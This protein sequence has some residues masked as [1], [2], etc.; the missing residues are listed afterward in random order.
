MFDS[1]SPETDRVTPPAAS[2]VLIVAF[3]FGDDEDDLGPI[4]MVCPYPGCLALD[5]I[6]Q[7]AAMVRW[8]GVEY[9]EEIGGIAIYEGRGAEDEDQGFICGACERP[10][11]LPEA[12]ANNINWSSQP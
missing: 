11:S 1:T 9:I 6:R 5:D 7:V 4:R 10:V 8:N 12:I 2:E 3:A